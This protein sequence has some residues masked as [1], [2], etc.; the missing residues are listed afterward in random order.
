MVQ[1]FVIGLRNLQ[2][3]QVLTCNVEYI[4]DGEEPCLLYSPAV[5][6]FG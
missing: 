5:V 1:M 4:L 2:T 3:L 6:D